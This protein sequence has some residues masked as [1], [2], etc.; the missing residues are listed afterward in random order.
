MVSKNKDQEDQTIIFL[1]IPKTAGS[2]LIRVMEQ[3]YRPEGVYSIVEPQDFQDLVGLSETKRAEFRLL[4]GHMDFGCHEL[5]PGPSTYFT[6]LRHPIERVISHY[7]FMLQEPQYQYYDIITA[8]HMNLR[9]FIESEFDVMMDNVQTRMLS[10]KGSQLTFGTCTEEVLETAKKNLREHF[11]LVGLTEKFDETL[12]LL[13]RAFG[14]KNLFYTRR[15]V[16]TNRPKQNELPAATLD[17]IINSN[18]LDMELYRYATMLFQEQVHRQGP[19][20]PVEVKLF[21]SANKLL[22]TFMKI[23]GEI[24][25]RS[26]RAFARKWIGVS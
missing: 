15:N 19:S 4:K 12:L 16:T 18:Q 26:I 10:G 7:Y 21:Q 5:L 24:R 22:N 1:H 14:W 11:T 17:T 8:S 23:Y 6:L 13:K 2:T 3:Q 25:K 9:K 20:F